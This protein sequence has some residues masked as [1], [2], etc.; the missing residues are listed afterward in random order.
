MDLLN[1][2]VVAHA[3]TRHGE[4]QLAAVDS[5]GET[6]FELIF[7]GVHLMATYNAPSSRALTD[8]ALSGIG[9]HRKHVELLIG[10]LGMGASLRQALERPEMETVRVVEL[11]FRIVDWNRT[12]LGNADLLDDRRTE[13]VVGDFYEYVKGSPQHYH[14]IVIDI[15]NGPDWVVRPENRRVYSISMLQVLRTRLRTDGI[16]AIWSHAVNRSYERA[17]ETVFGSVFK[18]MVQDVALNG[19]TLDSVIYEVH[20]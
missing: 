13:V 18:H 6:N 14:G 2:R 19:K 11:E 17:L 15:D 1:R 9:T 8:V 5:D 4:I 3:R 20:A 16:L 10:G 7:N 12:H